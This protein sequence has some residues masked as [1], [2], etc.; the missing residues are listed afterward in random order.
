M[1]LKHSTGTDKRLLAVQ[2]LKHLSS[3]LFSRE[4]VKKCKSYAG[5]HVMGCFIPSTQRHYR[6]LVLLLNT[7]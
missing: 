7:T 4:G 2:L 6:R 1:G 3:A 5:H